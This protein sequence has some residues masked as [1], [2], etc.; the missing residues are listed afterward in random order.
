MP[1]SKTPSVAA[2]RTRKGR[3]EAM[4]SVLAAT[5]DDRPP[6]YALAGLV[7]AVAD[8]DDRLEVLAQGQKQASDS[9]GKLEDKVATKLAAVK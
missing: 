5:I 3:L 9:V 6:A 7:G 2:A 8:I 1:R 4:R